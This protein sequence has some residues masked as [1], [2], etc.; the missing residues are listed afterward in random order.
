MVKLARFFHGQ[1]TVDLA[2]EEE[3]RHGVHNEQHLQKT[4]VS[5]FV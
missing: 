5:T 2:H 1:L 4:E 3:D